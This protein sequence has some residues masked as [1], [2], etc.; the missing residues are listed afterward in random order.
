MAQRAIGGAQ[1]MGSNFYKY[2]YNSSDHQQ[3][4]MC[5]SPIPHS[6]GY[7]HSPLCICAF[8]RFLVRFCK[9]N[10]CS[11]WSHVIAAYRIVYL[12]MSSV[13]CLLAG[14]IDRWWSLRGTNYSVFKCHRFEPVYRV[15]LS[16]GGPVIII[17]IKKVYSRDH[18][19]TRQQ[20]KSCSFS[21]LRFKYS[22]LFTRY[23][24]LNKINKCASTFNYYYLPGINNN[25]IILITITIHTKKLVQWVKMCFRF[26]NTGSVSF[27]WQWNGWHGTHHHPV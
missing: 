5:R 12:R 26:R 10:L 27:L 9:L 22:C 16:L 11:F 13:E 3:P 2:I 24:L 8:M 1:E 19:K 21:I 4:V 20:G 23:E 15:T 14:Y 6:P 17:S 18:G 25:S 7:T